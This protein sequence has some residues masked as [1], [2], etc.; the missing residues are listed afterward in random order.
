MPAPFPGM[1]P[2]LESWIWPDFQAS[3]ISALRAQLNAKLPRRY[4]ANTDLHLTT[5]LPSVE[6]KHRS[7]HVIE[8][9]QRRVVTVIEVLSPANKT[10]HGTEDSHRFK[11]GEY[12]VRGINLVEIDFLRDGVRRP[13][14]DLALP[15]VDYYALV[16]RASEGLLVG[17]WPIALRDPLPLI[18]LPLDPEESDILLD[19]RA[20][21]DRV[22]DEGRYAEQLDY[23][24]P[25]ALPLRE[26]DATWARGLLA[27]RFP[28]SP[29]V[30]GDHP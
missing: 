16:S 4:I 24:K 6:R 14:G 8:H 28:P 12:S 27:A 30:P 1:D 2:Y 26:P 15:V 13:L 18:P 21:L 5:V 11:R 10:A 17:I 3:M 25:P 20:A 7:L 19:L 23:L 22:Y 9:A 29:P